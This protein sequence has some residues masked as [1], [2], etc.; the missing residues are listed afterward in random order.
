MEE[1]FLLK[2]IAQH[3]FPPA[4]TRYFNSLGFQTMFQVVR[5]YD[6][7]LLIGQS[8]SFLVAFQ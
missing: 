5:K 7:N 6:R 2:K 8:Y 4:S 3:D 1:F